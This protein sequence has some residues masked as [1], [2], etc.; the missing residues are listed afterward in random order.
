MLVITWLRIAISSVATSYAALAASS[1][2][3]NT[4]PST[5]TTALS[6][7]ITSWLGTSS[8]CSIMLILRPTLYMIGTRKCRPG[9]PEEHTSELQ[10]LMRN[11]YADF[12]LQNKTYELHTHIVNYYP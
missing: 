5:F 10:S 8:T 7:V 6:L 2:W 1:T 3:K 12:C 11:S 4:M 9:R